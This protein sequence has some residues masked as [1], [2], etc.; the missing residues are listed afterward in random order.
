MN[1]SSSYRN[2]I[3]SLAFLVTFSVHLLMFSYGP[4]VSSIISEMSL[5]FTQASLIFS[6]SIIAITVIRI[7][8]GISCDHIGFKK[9]LGIG[10]F[11]MGIFGFLRSFSGTFVE[12]L[13]YPISYYWELGF[14]LLYPRCLIWFQIG[15]HKK[16]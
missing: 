4:L 2:V 8:W 16:K 12:L 1:D 7:P 15:F 10:L 5:N 11:I 3:L 9:S 6:V 13:I 14:Q